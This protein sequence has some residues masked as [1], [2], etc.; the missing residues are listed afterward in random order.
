MVDLTFQNSRLK[1]KQ[2]NRGHQLQLSEGQNFTEQSPWRP[3]P[4]IKIE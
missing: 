3:D 2:E 1:N 4:Q